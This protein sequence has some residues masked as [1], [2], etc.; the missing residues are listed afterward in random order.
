[1]TASRRRVFLAGLACCV[2]VIA[3]N[4]RSPGT[5]ADQVLQEFGLQRAS[6]EQDSQAVELFIREQMGSVA[7][8]EMR[9]LSNLPESNRV[10]SVPRP[11]DP[12]GASNYSKERRVYDRWYLVDITKGRTR[13]AGA[14]RSGESDRYVVT[15]EY[16]YRL[17]RSYQM[18]TREEAQATQSMVGTEVMDY[19]RYRYVFDG[20][21]NW[22]GKPG[23]LVR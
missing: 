5:V 19:E 22:D 4:C 23:R 20:N 1:M 7:L 3:A 2:A 8:R 15:V 9:R 14:G 16:R 21:G 11:N 10:V 13:G 12:L 17:F 18:P 6:S